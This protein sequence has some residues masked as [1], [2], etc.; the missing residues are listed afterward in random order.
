MV[1][2]NP[3]TGTDFQVLPLPHSI[4]QTVILPVTDEHELQGIGIIMDNM[5]VMI[6]A[7][8]L[9]SR[10]KQI[11]FLGLRLSRYSRRSFFDV[12]ETKTIRGL[13]G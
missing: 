4:K 5:K 12:V 6:M 7:E 11:F 13:L 9:Q 10:Y 1:A 8:G 3:I 2:F